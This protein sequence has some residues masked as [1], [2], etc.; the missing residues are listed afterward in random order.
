MNH[1]R[2]LV[3]GRGRC[4]VFCEVVGSP[5]LWVMACYGLIQLWVNTGLTVSRYV[6]KSDFP[7]PTASFNRVKA[8]AKIQKFMTPEVIPPELQVGDRQKSG[9][10]GTLHTSC[11][12]LQGGQV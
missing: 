10:S 7:E 1:R 8:A 12:R 2:V 3:Y 5:N 11:K 6:V 9:T 4:R